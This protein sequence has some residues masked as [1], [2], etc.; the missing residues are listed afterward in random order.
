MVLASSTYPCRSGPEPSRSA[1]PC[2][3]QAPAAPLALE[4]VEAEVVLPSFR[5]RRKLE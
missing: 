5:I 2:W 4:P 3:Y 1:I